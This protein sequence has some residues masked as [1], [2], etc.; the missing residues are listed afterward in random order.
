MYD[1]HIDLD[2]LAR[3]FHLFV[4]LGFVLFLWLLLLRQPLAAQHSPQAFYAAFVS[5]TSQSC[6]QFNDAECRIAPAHIADEYQFF[7]GMLVRMAVRLS[8]MTCQRIQYF[9]RSELSRS[10]CTTGTC[11][12]CGT[13]LKRQISQHIS[14]GSSGIS[15]PVIYYSG[16]LR[17]FFLFGCNLTIADF[18]SRLTS[19]GM[20][21]LQN[22][23]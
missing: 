12:I 5:T 17:S 10:I 16:G 20:F 18:R 11:C 4:G 7:L 21:A 14:L 8:G 6:P 13:L 15:Y 2:T 1:F 22:V 19:F 23:L 9:H 3:I